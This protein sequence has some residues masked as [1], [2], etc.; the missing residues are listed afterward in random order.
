MNCF[1]TIS[2][3][4]TGS[5]LTRGNRVFGFESIVGKAQVPRQ[6]I[7]YDF[8]VPSS[9]NDSVW[10]IIANFSLLNLTR[11][12]V[13]CF[14]SRTH[15]NKVKLG[16]AFSERASQ[17]LRRHKC[18][19]HGVYFNRDISH[20]PPMLALSKSNPGEREGDLIK[21]LEHYIMDGNQRIRAGASWFLFYCKCD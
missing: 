7:W 14:G 8:F 18:L 5:R 11:S 16:F 2:S 19:I 10:S 6:N 21:T 1:A 12:V 20:A 15:L 13:D 3:P 17:N 9:S 4:L